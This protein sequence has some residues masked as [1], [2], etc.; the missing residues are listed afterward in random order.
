MKKKKKLSRKLYFRLFVKSLF[1]LFFCFLVLKGFSLLHPARLESANLTSATAT[2]AN[3]RLSYKSSIGSAQ[4]VGETTIT[5][6]TDSA[7]DNTNHLFPGDTICFVNSAESGC[8]GDKTYNVGTIVDDTN[9]TITSALTNN[10]ADSDFIVA[11]QSGALTITF[12][13]VGAIPANGDILITIPALDSNGKTD[14]GIPDTNTNLSANGFDVGNLAAG[15]IST[16]GCTDG[17]WVATETIVAGG[18]SSDTTIR[19]DRQNTVC[20][21]S[22]TI[23]VTIGSTNYLINPAPISSGHTQGTADYYSIT[24]QTRDGADSQIDSVDVMVAPVEAVRVTATVEEVLTFAIEGVG[25]GNSHCGTSAVVDVTTLPYSVPFGSLT[26]TAGIETFKEAEHKLTVTT[27]ADGG[28]KVYVYED[29]ELGKDG[30][31]SP[32]IPDTTCGTSACDHTT[33]QNWVDAAAYNGFGYS[34]VNSSGTDAKFQYSGGTWYAKQFPNESELA[35]QYDDTDAEVMLHSGP[36]NGSSL[37][38]CYRLSADAIQEAGY[39][40]N[41]LKYIATPTF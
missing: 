34:L 32:Y 37:Y 20:T 22:S 35:G 16:T 26:T 30:A 10:L 24:A 7:D 11:S 4:S 5:I 28:Y 13:T 40:Y 39:Y 18:V 12:T 21:A 23:T 29:D 3:S 19:I 2:L 17:D 8:I 27:N 38:V 15:D 31:D 9:F 36:V 33:P 1:W 41:T 6:D 14:D 25:L